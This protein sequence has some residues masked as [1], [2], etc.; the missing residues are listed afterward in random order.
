MIDKEK[1]L[2][3]FLPDGWEWQY[4]G[5]YEQWVV[6]REKQAPRFE[7]G[8]WYLHDDGQTK[9]HWKCVGVHLVG[10]N[11]EAV[12]HVKAVSKPEYWTP[13]NPDGSPLAPEPEVGD[14]WEDEHQARFTITAHTVYRAEGEEEPWM[15]EYSE[16]PAEAVDGLTFVRRA[17]E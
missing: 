2:S 9:I 17:G 16:I 3:A 5:A 12:L 6:A 4:N 14:V 8:K 10:Y 15:L 7:D 1:D 11:L 13:C